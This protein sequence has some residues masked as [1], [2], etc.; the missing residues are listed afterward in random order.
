MKFGRA[1]FNNR[2]P[3]YAAYYIEYK[4]L[5]KAIRLITGNPKPG[6]TTTLDLNDTHSPLITFH[7]L[8]QT[9]LTKVNRFAAIQ[10]DALM[11]DI[12]R[13]VKAKA[14]GLGD[15]AK[16]DSLVK[17]INALFNYVV[18]NYT[19]ICRTCLGFRKITKKF[20]RAVNSCDASW[21]LQQNVMTAPVSIPRL[22]PSH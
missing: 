14:D 2:Y 15:H 12:K 21:F 9:E 6:E 16:A 7:G 1:L 22:V 20:N 19:G 17:D 5:K 8:L 11:A 18:L 3:S 13:G 4:E 10:F